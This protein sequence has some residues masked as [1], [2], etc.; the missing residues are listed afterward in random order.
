MNHIHTFEN[1]LNEERLNVPVNLRL[2]YQKWIESEQPGFFGKDRSQELRMK[3]FFKLLDGYSFDV[4]CKFI[5][6]L[7]DKYGKIPQ[8]LRSYYKKIYLI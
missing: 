6:V 2:A 3:E 4:Q 7:D 8:R 5:K 1:F